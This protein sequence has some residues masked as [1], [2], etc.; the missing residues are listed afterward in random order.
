MHYF[1][2]VLLLKDMNGVCVLLMMNGLSNM[3]LRER[4]EVYGINRKVVVLRRQ[5]EGVPNRTFSRRQACELLP[6]QPPLRLREGM[7]TPPP[8]I[9][10]IHSFTQCL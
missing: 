4:Q 8:H 10:Q 2:I 6:I 5:K 9:K 7:G 1:L 3:K